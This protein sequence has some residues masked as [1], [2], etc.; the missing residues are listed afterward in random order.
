MY[1]NLYKLETMHKNQA[2]SFFLKM[3][4]MMSQ[5]SIRFKGFGFINLNN[6]TYN[7][8]SCIYKNFHSDFDYKYG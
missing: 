2:E 8:V 5:R 6:K 7:D 1:E 3:I 4:M